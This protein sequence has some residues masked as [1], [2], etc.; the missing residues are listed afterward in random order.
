MI[1]EVKIIHE[2]TIS[3]SSSYVID[4][5]PAK[6]GLKKPKIVNSVSERPQTTRE[7]M[8][9]PVEVRPDV[10]FSHKL[11][12]LPKYLQKR[13][14]QSAAS[15]KCSLV[16]KINEGRP[17]TVDP[18]MIELQ[19]A[20]SKVQFLV[21]PPKELQGD[22]KSQ[23]NLSNKPQKTSESKSKIPLLTKDNELLKHEC[24]KLKSNLN[25]VNE[26][27]KSK[28]AEIKSL[29]MH[30]AR[31]QK[32]IKQNAEIIDKQ[33][34]SEAEITNLKKNIENL[35]GRLKIKD[36]VINR[37]KNDIEKLDHELK[38]HMSS[39]ETLTMEK[40]HLQTLLNGLKK[41]KE[42]ESKEQSSLV[43]EVV[44]LNEQLN[45]KC[46]QIAELKKKV[47]RLEDEVVSKI[48]NLF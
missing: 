8:K 39:F 33:L 10:K 48:L 25:E 38:M 2:S 19:R 13:K 37:L 31:Y 34:S 23:M 46:E 44:A 30:V 1:D 45:E 11:G 4:T 41:E 16:N 32:E 17:K 22:V 28:S 21:K 12:E 27:L 40:T 20:S 7:R 42:D 14:E 29:K 26:H 43:A 6:K 5:K 9:K 24:E 36:D 35:N 15:S 3:A 18:S 47:E